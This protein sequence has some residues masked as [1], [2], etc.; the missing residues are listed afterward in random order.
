MSV[1]CLGFQGDDGNVSLLLHLPCGRRIW[2]AAGLTTRPPSHGET[3][4]PCALS[5]RWAS[6]A[7]SRFSAGGRLLRPLRQSSV[8]A[9]F[10]NP[11]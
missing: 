3:K 4:G 10:P 6:C 9:S 7:A 11:G 8:T 1:S 5:G 2:P